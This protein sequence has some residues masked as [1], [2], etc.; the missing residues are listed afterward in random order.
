MAEPKLQ[1]VK[2]REGLVLPLLDGSDWPLDEDGEPL[3]VQVPIG[4]ADGKAGRFWRGRLSDGD[5]VKSRPP[6]PTK[7]ASKA[8]PAKKGDE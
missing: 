3:A 1:Y 6:Q 7:P 5:V 2:P 8:S 4:N